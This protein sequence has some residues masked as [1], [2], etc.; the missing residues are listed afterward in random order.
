MNE[1]MT[2]P[3]TKSVTKQV[4]KPVT[5]PETKSVTKL[6]I[7]LQFWTK[8]L[9]NGQCG[10]EAAAKFSIVHGC[11]YINLKFVVSVSVTVS[12]ESIGQLEFRFWYR[13]E[14]KIV[15]SVVH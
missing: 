10:V 14:T 6:N 4:T 5:K 11:P 13:T 2:K 9:K 12:A 8:I 3:V 7:I 1:P 15:V